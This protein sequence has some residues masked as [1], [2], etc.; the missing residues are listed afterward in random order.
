[1]YI[2]STKQNYCDKNFLN[3]SPILKGTVDNRKFLGY[4]PPK[5]TLFNLK[6]VINKQ[7]KVVH[8]CTKGKR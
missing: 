7:K 4:K 2:R 1:M 8:L 6:V 5:V 3:N